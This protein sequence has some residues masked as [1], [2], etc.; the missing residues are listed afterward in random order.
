[1]IGN[2]AGGY[3][4]TADDC[5]RRIRGTLL[6]EAWANCLHGRPGT[7]R[8]EGGQVGGRDIHGGGRCVGRANG[9]RSGY[10]MQIVNLRITGITGE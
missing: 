5:R 9:V 7:R 10:E 1:M 3:P 8:G 6:A 4:G 2:M